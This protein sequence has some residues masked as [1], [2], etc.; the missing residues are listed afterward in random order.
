[1]DN[2]KNSK[3]IR[4]GIYFFGALIVLLLLNYLLSGSNQDSIRDYLMNNGY[5]LES[6]DETRLFKLIDAN[7]INYFSVAD[8][9]F[10]QNFNENNESFNSMLTSRYDFKNHELTY[11]YRTTYGNNVNVIYKG[12]YI[13]DE[14]ICDKEFST[15]SILDS[16]KENTCNLIKLKV[17]R[18]YKEASILFNSHNMIKY[19]EDVNLD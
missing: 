7:T 2:I 15:V 14:F 6:D 16:E 10:T 13:D 9:T 19:M 17:E 11:N 8:Y 1:M 4:V 5:I 3:T 12:S 18:F